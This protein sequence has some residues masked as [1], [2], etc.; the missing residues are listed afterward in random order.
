MIQ[1]AICFQMWL[2]YFTH[3]LLLKYILSIVHLCYVSGY[4]E[5]PTCGVDGYIV[6]LR[7][8]GLFHL[9][10]RGLSGIVI[11]IFQYLKGTYR[12]AW[13][14]I[15]NYSDKTWGNGFKLKESKFRLDVRKKLFTVGMVRHWNR[16]SGKIVDAPNMSVFNARLEGTL[17]NLV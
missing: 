14:A 5:L 6:R 13:E 7:K 11:A 10:K 8:L 3:T 1:K 4:F 2:V 15:R 9:E 16:L 17:S 12:E